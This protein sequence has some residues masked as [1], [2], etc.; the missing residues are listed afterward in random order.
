MFFKPKKL[1]PIIKPAVGNYD[2]KKGWLQVFGVIPLNM[3]YFS[4]KTKDCYHR[5][6]YRIMKIT[7]REPLRSFG[8][9]MTSISYK[10]TKW[11]APIT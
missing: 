7:E 4:F 1:P 2:G 11:R 10:A 8:Q 9:A 5:P 6:I 3:K